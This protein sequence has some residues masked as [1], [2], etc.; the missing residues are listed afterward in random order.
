MFK[1]SIFNVCFRHLGDDYIYNSL[2]GALVKGNLTQY[3]SDLAE[4][5]NIQNELMKK[6]FIVNA[7]FNEFGYITQKTYDAIYNLFPTDISFTIVVTSK[8]NYSCKYCFEG[9]KISLNDIDE[10]KTADFIIK[11]IQSNPTLKH[12]RITWFGG[13]PFLNSLAIRRITERILP[14]IESRKIIYKGTVVTNG[15]FI[16]IDFMRQM[17]I[18]SAQITLDGTAKTYALYKGVNEQ[19]FTKVIQNIETIVSS[20]IINLAIRLNC[21]KNN[22]DS[23]L[24]LVELLDQANLLNQ[25]YTYLAPINTGMTSDLSED[26]FYELQ[27][28]YYKYLSAHGYKAQLLKQLH[29]SRIMS[30]G[31]MGN[32]SYVLDVDGS[33]KKCERDIGF[34]DKSVGDIIFGKY[35]NNVEEDY[36]RNDILEKCVNFNIYPICRGGCR[37]LREHGDDIN[38]AAKKK[39]LIDLLSII[40]NTSNVICS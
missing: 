6:G 20:K 15:S 10:H 5:N 33:L 34:D 37:K 21:D 35:Y 36:Q 13:E 27:V 29:K 8:C 25:T 1:E 3:I 40:I 22:I 18:S 16:D 11:Q 26:E 12:I 2:S 7:Q 24:R 30:C 38:C 19:Y 39:H 23:I 17:Q 28:N 32:G 4:N 31:F 9:D 14:I